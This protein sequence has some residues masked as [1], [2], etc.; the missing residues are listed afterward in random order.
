MLFSLNILKI[1]LINPDASLFI[2]RDSKIY[3]EDWLTYS[4]GID[5]PGELCYIFSISN[6]LTQIVEL[7]TGIPVLRSCTFRFISIFRP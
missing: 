1:L 2:F 6:N 7:P 5:A 4:V 3:D